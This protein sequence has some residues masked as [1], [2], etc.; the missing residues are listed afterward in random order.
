VAGS[1]AV[2]EHRDVAFAAVRCAYSAWGHLC[3]RIG[4]DSTLSLARAGTVVRDQ[5]AFA[6]DREVRRE[7]GAQLCV[8]RN[9]LP[10][11]ARREL[12]HSA[13]NGLPAIA[14]Y[15]SVSPTTAY[16]NHVTTGA[17]RGSAGRPASQRAKA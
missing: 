11:V 4:D 13:P 1:G 6:A 9:L 17:D 3:D 2:D 5:D 16:I 14:E 10:H 8:V 12:L 15:S 7:F